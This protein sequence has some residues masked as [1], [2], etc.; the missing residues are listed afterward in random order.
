MTRV[1]SYQAINPD[2]TRTAAAYLEG[3]KRETEE[4]IRPSFSIAVM[5]SHGAGGPYL[6]S[7]TDPNTFFHLSATSNHSDV[8]QTTRAPTA[9]VKRMICDVINCM[10][11]KWS[12]HARLYGSIK[13]R[14]AAACRASPWCSM[15]SPSSLV[16]LWDLTLVLVFGAVLR[17][18]FVH[19][20][21]PVLEYTWLSFGLFFYLEQLKGAVHYVLPVQNL[22]HWRV[23]NCSNVIL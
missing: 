21:N 23:N 2:V 18:L 8:K 14:R 15:S 19:F 5:M 6:A 12:S 13:L 16:W 10:S 3:R 9:L 17:S 1:G 20:P 22:Q 7:A 4:S 11:N